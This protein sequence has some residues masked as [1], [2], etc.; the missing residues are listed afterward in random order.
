MLGMA[1]D[2]QDENAMTLVLGGMGKTGRR[3]V[4]RLTARGVPTVDGVR[5][6]FVD[7]GDI[8]DVAVAA[9]TEAGHAGQPYELTG[10]RLLTFAEAVHEIA[11]ATGREIRLLPVP[12]DEFAAS[13]FAHD[14]P[15]HAVSL[16]THLFTEVLDG[17]NASLTDGVH[18]AL[19]RQPRD[20]RDCARDTA[21]TGVWRG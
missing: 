20:F 8:A 14:V 9:L 18:R 2:T 12:V 21:A 5:E 6:P 16:L 11:G 10:P 7:A 13:L 1:T 15:A 19:G 3:V 4:E 17:R